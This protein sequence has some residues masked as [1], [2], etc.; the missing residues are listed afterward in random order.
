MKGLLLFL[1]DLNTTDGCGIFCILF[2]KSNKSAHYQFRFNDRGTVFFL[3][4]FLF[5]F[6]FQVSQILKVGEHQLAH[7]SRPKREQLDL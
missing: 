2:I 5:L 7:T 1:N 4:L 3:F 6:L